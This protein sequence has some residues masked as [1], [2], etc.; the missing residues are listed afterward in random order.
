MYILFLPEIAGMNPSNPNG[1][2]N[3]E[4]TEGEFQF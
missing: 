4:D 3:Q 1:S 2:T